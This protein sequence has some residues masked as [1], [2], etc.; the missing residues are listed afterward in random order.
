MSKQWWYRLSL[1][2]CLLAGSL[3]AAGCKNE[4]GEPLRVAPAGARDAAN[5]D[6][7]VAKD[8]AL[9]GDQLAAAQL[10][11]VYSK[12]DQEQ[13]LYWLRVGAENGHSLSQYNFA[14]ELWAHGKAPEDEQL[15][16]TFWL[17]RAAAAGDSEAAA[18][19]ARLKD[20]GE[21]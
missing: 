18:V 12:T 2:A 10:Q 14:F 8:L 13:Y 15:R 17:G 11:N 21:W 16:A 6:L 5:R 7:E 20:G 1:M 3:L 4:V 19:L 9:A